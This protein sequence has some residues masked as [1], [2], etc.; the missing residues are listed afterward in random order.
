MPVVMAIQPLRLMLV[1]V[2]DIEQVMPIS[3]RSRLQ[4][5]LFKGMTAN[6]MLKTST[7]ADPTST[8]HGL[9]VR[10]FRIQVYDASAHEKAPQKP[11]GSVRAQD[12][13]RT[14]TPL[15]ALR[16]EHSASTNFATWAGEE[17]FRGPG[18]LVQG[19]QR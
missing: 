17:E 8:A 2:G 4:C 10:G 18:F 13:I 7:T 5:M 11:R 15:R 9:S 3:N 14:S 19:W 1:S 6:I 16:P 12:W